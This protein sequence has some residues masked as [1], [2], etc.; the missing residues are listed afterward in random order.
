M[1][2]DSS[3]LTVKRGDAPLI[4][5]L[6]HTGVEIP[7]PYERGLVSPWRARRDT[8]WWI[9]LLYDFA[10]ELDATIIHTAISRTVIDVNRDPSGASLY[11]GQPT[12]DLC[13]TT[14][15]DGEPL[16]HSGAEPTAESI[17]ERRARFLEPYHEAIA[18][19]SRRLR[20]MHPKIV[21]YDCHSIRSRIPRLF[22][23]LLPNFNI[24]TNNGTTCDPALSTAVADVCSASGFS[25]VVN[26]RFKGG[27]ITRHFGDP[28]SG[29]NAVQME[30]A[31]RGYLTEPS[32]KVSED[33]WPPAY[34]DQISA[35]IRETLRRILETCLSFARNQRS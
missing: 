19:E 13:P 4:I 6:P 20:A 9:D 30:L 23:G 10:T 8:D 35:P 1:T 29:I 31:C 32:E 28:K 25:F 34:D 33:N 16:Y 15:F 11:P 18:H 3:W 14:T 24:G 21:V 2:L 22:E 7:V 27:Y 26:G 5:S 12:T 17:G